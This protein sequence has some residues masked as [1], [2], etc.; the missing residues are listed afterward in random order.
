MGAFQHLRAEPGAAREIGITIDSAIGGIVT[1]CFTRLPRKGRHCGETKKKLSWD[2]STGSN[3]APTLMSEFTS[4]RG[5]DSAPVLPQSEIAALVKALTHG[6]KTALVKVARL[7]ARKT[8]YEYEDLL[9]EAFSRV[10]AGD[11]TWRRDLPAVTFF[12]GVMRSI[13]WEWRRNDG[14]FVEEFELSDEGVEARGVIARLDVQRVL[15]LFDDDTVA[16]KLAV[17]MMVGTKA[18]ELQAAFGLSS[19]EYESK[20][21]K[22][23]RRI[24]KLQLE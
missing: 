7:Y 21:K 19:T 1:L 12:S 11:R 17:Q 23:R 24:E 5:E 14:S 3:H 16:R 2:V 13:A 18:E 9:Q 10:L 22:I 20:R 4:E 15:S 6:Q 8:T